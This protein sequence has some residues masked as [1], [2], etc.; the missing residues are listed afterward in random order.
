MTAKNKNWS[1]RR[2]LKATGTAGLVKPGDRVDVQWYVKRG[3]AE[4]I[5]ETSM[6]IILDDAKVFAVDQLWQRASED[7]ATA[8]Q[9]RSVSLLLTPDQAAKLDLGM[10]MGM[11]HLSLRNPEDDS[12]ASTRPATLADLRYHQ[13]KPLSNMAGKA[14]KFMAGLW[15]GGK[16]APQTEASKDQQPVQYRTA[17]IRTLRGSSRGHIRIDT[18]P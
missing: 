7:E 13:E 8:V 1:R 10:N 11:L 17:N 14:G 12:E 3:A 4:G 16:D 5:N 9:A 6:R 15:A 2:F 18:A